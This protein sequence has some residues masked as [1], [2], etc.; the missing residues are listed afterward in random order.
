MKPGSSV[1]DRRSSWLRGWDDASRLHKLL[2]PE[3]IFG[4][5]SLAQFGTALRRLGASRVLL[6]SDPGV[7]AAGWVEAAVPALSRERLK[8][9]L[10]DGITPNPKDLEVEAGF[11]AYVSS[12]ADAVAAVGGGSSIDAAKGIAI[13]SAC[14]GRILDYVGI[15][16]VVGP[17]PPMVMAPSTAGTGADVTQFCVVTDTSRRLKRTIASRALLPDVSITDPL[18]LSTVPDEIRAYTALDALSHAI[19]AHVSAAADFLTDGYAL[20]AIRTIR[21]N[22]WAVVRDS[23]NLPAQEAMATASL[24]AG[25]AFSNASLG[26]THA[27]SHQIGGALDLPHGLLNAVL[28]PHVM[29]F[30][31]EACPERYREVARAV[32][33]DR[34]SMTDPEAAAATVDWVTELARGLG[35]PTR[36][37]EIG[38]ALPQIDEYARNALADAYITTNPREVRFEDA[39]QICLAAF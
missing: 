19:E 11:S 39:R 5:G 28:L 3:V 23:G 4:L 8:W 10:W 38:V 35:V 32:G 20:S 14:G 22:C 21:D 34:P 37:R 9:T 1:V 17:V 7:V 2:V 6:V 12:G 18:L 27:I 31:A 36:L 13:L 29:A 26:A 15:D 33:V 16:Q 30:N 25:L 24:Q